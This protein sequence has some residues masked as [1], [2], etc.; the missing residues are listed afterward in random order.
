M[1][2]FEFEQ[3]SDIQQAINRHGSS[4]ALIAGGTTL[5]DLVKLDVMRPEKVVDV[6]HLPL[7]QVES[8]ADGRLKVGALV[9]NADLARHDSV[10]RDY[11]IVSEAL[12]AGAS[13]GLRN[14]ATTAGNVMQRTRCPYFRDPDMPCNK[15]EPGSGC[16]AIEGINRNHA[17]LGTS[18]KCIATHPSDM[19][20][21][22]VAAGATVVVEGPQGVREIPFEEY[23]LLPGETPE[24]E[25]DLMAGELI[26][27][28][29]L[30]PPRG[31]GQSYLKL[32]DRSSY[33]FALASCAAIVNLDGDTITEAR[34]AM[35][36][37]AT[38]PWRATPAEEA[39]KGQPATRETFERAAEAVMQDAVAYSHNGYKITL[40]KQ[41]VARALRDAANRARA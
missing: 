29:I 13:T 19:C 25:H 30:D 22:M 33:E 36:G 10:L 20:V 27:H 35:G 21:G 9:S 11:P 16:S 31:G 3:A 15:R 26:T 5:L 1:R 14:M 41:A 38:K 7:R 4:D 40:G 23:H 34:V 37:V 39:L 18:D 2:G 8:L 12:L 24:Q 32:R 6:T 28:V 17:V